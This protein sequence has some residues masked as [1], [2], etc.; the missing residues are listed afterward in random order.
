[1]EM[2]FSGLK[3]LSRSA[4][5]ISRNLDAAY[6]SLSRQVTISLPHLSIERS[7]RSE[8]TN[9]N[10]SN[11]SSNNDNVMENCETSAPQPKKANNIEV[12]PE[13]AEYDNLNM[14][15]SQ[16]DQESMKSSAGVVKFGWDAVAS[17]SPYKK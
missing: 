5:I 15:V 8:D 10:R 9:S 7:E 14:S 13:L 12:A 11:I 2:Y 6:N 17:N 16:E 4:D 3:N 1:M